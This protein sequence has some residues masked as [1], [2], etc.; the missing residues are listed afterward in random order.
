M[1]DN[2]EIVGDQHNRHAETL[3]ERAQQFQYLRL[4]RH[5]K[6]RRRLVG[7][8]DVGFVGKR[9]GDHDALPLAAGQFMRVTVNAAGGIGNADQFQEFQ[10]AAAGRFPA[11]AAVVDDRFGDLAADRV[12]R[13]ER[14]HRL[15]KDHRDLGTAD[16][17][18]LVISQSDQFLAPI[19][20]GASDGAVSSEQAHNAHHRLALAGAAFADDGERLAG[21]DIEADA[22]DR[23]DRAIRRREIHFQVADRENGVFLI[24]HVNDPS[25]RARRAGRRR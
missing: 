7:D 20:G 17:V 16:L 12:K 11:A 24:G 15:L 23:I 21:T 14:G 1:P 3:L 5:I 4:D 8:Q 2:A 22:L 10:H 9:H 18:E 19:G 6:R 25:G 13:I